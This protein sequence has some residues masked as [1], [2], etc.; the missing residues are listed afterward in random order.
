M[1]SEPRV[2][3]DLPKVPQLAKPWA[4]GSG[5]PSPL[6]PQDTCLCILGTGGDPVQ[7]HLPTRLLSPRATDAG[8]QEATVLVQPQPAS[9]PGPPSSCKRGW[10]QW[11]GGQNPLIIMRFDWPEMFLP[12]AR[13]AP[14][15]ERV[16][17]PAFAEPDGLSQ[18]AHISAWYATGVRAGV[19]P[20]SQAIQVNSR[21]GFLLLLPPRPLPGAVFVLPNGK[22]SFTFLF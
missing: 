14:W 6:H 7:P 3:S 12:R 10:G 16:A 22:V 17:P 13:V 2:A 4:A 1:G 8:K 9:P 5:P 18:R 19:Q 21:K 20:P 15:P 11:W